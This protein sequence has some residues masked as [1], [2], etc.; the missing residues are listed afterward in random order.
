[1]SYRLLKSPNNVLS[2]NIVNFACHSPLPLPEEAFELRSHA[3]TAYIPVSNVSILVPR[4]EFRS[5]NNQRALQ[6]GS[7]KGHYH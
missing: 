7:S 5:G 3:G 1:M 6:A 2:N 4:P